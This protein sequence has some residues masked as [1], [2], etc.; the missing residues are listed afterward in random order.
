MTSLKDLFNDFAEDLLKKIDEIKTSQDS[1][2]DEEVAWQNAKEMLIE[3]YI[4][5]IKNRLIG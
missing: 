1:F 2:E 4:T 3:E 5:N